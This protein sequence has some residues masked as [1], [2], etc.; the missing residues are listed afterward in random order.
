MGN[1]AYIDGQN[2]NLATTKADV[3]WKVDFSRF[4]SYLRKRYDVE[5]A[6]YFMG[7]HNPKYE[8]MYNMLRK[9]GFDVVFR[10]HSKNLKSD[11]GGN[12]DS[13]VV[14]S[15]MRDMHEDENPRLILVSGDGDYIKTVR[16]LVANDRMEKVL[17][18]SHWNASSLY[19]EIPTRCKA[20]LDD[21]VV[22]RKIER[23]S[24]GLP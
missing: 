11:K 15:M 19:K 12:V 10:E 2:L 5:T 22:R 9:S 16:Y 6:F 8:G 7:V 24:G 17:F 3:P 20:Y 21:S 23:T 18:P 13:D 4:R 14:F 1:I